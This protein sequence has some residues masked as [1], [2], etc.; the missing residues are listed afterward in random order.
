MIGTS[1][2][3][4]EFTQTIT[5][6]LQEKFGKEFQIFAHTVIKN[7]DRKK[8]GISVQ[9]KGSGLSPTIYIDDL[10]HA[11]ITQE[12][13]QQ[14]AECLQKEF[15]QAEMEEMD[16]SAFPRFETARKQLAFKLINKE[17]N[18][19]LLRETPHKIFYDLA[20]VF[21]YSVQEAPF[22]G[23]AAIT[24]T[25][26]H[27]Q[28]WKRNTEELWE[29][30]LE[31]SLRLF[32]AKIESMEKVMKEMISTPGHDGQNAEGDWQEEL[33]KEAGRPDDMRMYVLSNQEKL[34]GAACMLYPEVLSAFGK[35]CGRDFYVLPSSI[36][37]VLLVFAEEGKEKELKEIVTD[38]NRNHVAPEEVLSDSIYHYNTKKG[39]LCL[40]L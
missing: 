40:L 17:K 37:E 34:Y 2:P 28:L 7:N 4:E 33:K 36:H 11:G 38:M 6:L 26:S 25:Q 23:R 16:L 13:V 29:A 20:A 19:E 5:S 18:K 8:T 24:V 10:Y 30:A 1:I 9:R 15:K 39:S 21:Y 32:P 27:M 12:E 35:I 31:N 22:Y 3:F 14:I